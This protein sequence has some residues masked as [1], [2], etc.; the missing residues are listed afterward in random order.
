MSSVLSPQDADLR[1]CKIILLQGK[2]PKIKEANFASH[3][4]E[5]IIELSVNPGLLLV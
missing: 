3:A 5:S 1:F 4:F 2:H